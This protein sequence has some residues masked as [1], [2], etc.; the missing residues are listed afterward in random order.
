MSDTIP[1]HLRQGYRLAFMGNSDSHRIVPGMG[2]ALTG[3]WAEELTRESIFEALRARRCFATNGE[4]TVL[5]VRVN[6]VPMGAETMVQ[7]E[8]TLSCRVRAPRRVARVELFRDGVKIL[9]RSAGSREVTADLHD[10]PAPGQHFYYVQISLRP[11]PRRPMRG[12]CGNLQVARGD[13][14]WS[15]PIWVTV[16]Q[17][18][19]AGTC[20]G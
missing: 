8:V 17:I 15:S 5:D 14:A 3:V 20:E 10:R 2:G 11:L 16:Q 19:P 13:L 12:R 1:E 9:S 6:G 18:L 7:G 4:R